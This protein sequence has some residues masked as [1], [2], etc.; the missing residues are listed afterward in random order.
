M[1][2]SI[3]VRAEC[4]DQHNEVAIKLGIIYLSGFSNFTCTLSSQKWEDS[5]EKQISETPLAPCLWLGS[6]DKKTKYSY[7]GGH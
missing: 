2:L 3:L 7:I 1:N 6:Q 4:M 5:N